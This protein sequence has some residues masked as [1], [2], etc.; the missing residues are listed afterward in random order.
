MADLINILI[1]E[2]IIGLGAINK[3]ADIV[4]KLAPTKL[5]LITD[6][7][8]VKSGVIDNIRLP[9]EK[10]QCEFEIFDGCETEPSISSIDELGQRIRVRKYDLLIGVGGGSVMDTTKLASIIA[11]E[12]I[13]VYDLIGG[14][15]ADKAVVKILIPTTAGTGAEWS[16]SAVVSDDKAGRMSKLVRANKNLPDK[17][18]ID[19]ELTLNLPPTITAESGMDALTHAIE[20][21]VSAKANT[22]SDMFAETA[23]K[24][25]AHNLRRAYRNGNRDVEA[26]YQ[27]CVAASLAMKAVGLASVGLDHYMNGSLGRKAHISHGAA[28]AILLPHVMEFNRPVNPTRFARVAGLM[29]ETTNTLS[30]LEAAARS[31]E[32]VERLSRDLEMRQTMGDAGIT[33]ADVPAMADEVYSKTHP[34]VINETNPRAATREDIIQVFNRAL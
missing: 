7:G 15:I 23:L 30:P 6:A 11:A 32:A 17:V 13:S 9:L 25:V 10:A 31:V 21:Y 14:R 20:A 16:T 8:L 26:R 33:A 19:P 3:I 2:T 5:L 1:P 22:I 27:M 34:K 4:K 24:L 28:C 18:I 29:G 12:G